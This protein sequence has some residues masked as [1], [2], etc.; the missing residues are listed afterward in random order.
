VTPISKLVLHHFPATRSVRARWALLETVGENFEVR[1]VELYDGAQYHPDFLGMNPNHNVPVLEIYWQ[2][3]TTQTMLE[4]VA[5]VEWLADRHPEK[6]LAPLAEDG[7]ARADY[8]H[9][10]HFAGTWFDMMLWQVRIHE[11]ILPPGERDER[12]VTRYRKKVA[13][14]VEP[15][16]LA[17]LDRHD[18]I[19]GSAFSA[20]DI[21]VGHCVFWA[22]GYGLCQ[23]ERFGAY[24][25]RL[26]QREAMQK[27]LDDLDT[28]TIA[29]GS[30]QKLKATFSG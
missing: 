21:V 14:E 25:H 6:N 27:A 29:P 9:M 30:D 12:T 1:R 7:P 2:D 26:M 3:G 10:L 22:R 20:A 5:I 15:Q 28:F 16:L 17:R 24:L 8:L 13:R 23:D 11:H 4:S 19:C 18:F